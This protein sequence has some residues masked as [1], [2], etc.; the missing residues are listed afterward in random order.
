MDKMQALRDAL[1]A[2]REASLTEDAS[3]ESPNRAK[4][5]PET[6]NTL[7]RVSTA[8]T[9]EWTREALLNLAPHEVMSNKIAFELLI[10]A[11]RGYLRTLGN[12]VVIKLGRKALN[13]FLRTGSVALFDYVDIGAEFEAPFHVPGW[14]PSGKF[15]VK[16]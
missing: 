4:T 2:L 1:D 14:K 3:V 7:E 13:R 12:D 15:T 10:G 16:P 11:R 5:V 6:A 8:P 9:L